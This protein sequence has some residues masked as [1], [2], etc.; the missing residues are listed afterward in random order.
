MPDNAKQRIVMVVDVPSDLMRATFGKF[1][2]GL[3][4][5]HRCKVVTYWTI[6]APPPTWEAFR[7]DSLTVSASRDPLMDHVTVDEP[8]RN[9]TPPG[10]TPTRRHVG[11][12]AY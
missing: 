8:P 7:G 1:I 12:S 6:E 2:K 5:Y 11:S 10:T 4:R 9:Q 3:G